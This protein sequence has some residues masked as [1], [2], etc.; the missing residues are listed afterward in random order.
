MEN[1]SMFVSLAFLLKYPFIKGLMG[2]RSGDLHNSGLAGDTDVRF[3]LDRPNH[4][5]K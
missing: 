4:A 3:L 2:R 5:I 1:L